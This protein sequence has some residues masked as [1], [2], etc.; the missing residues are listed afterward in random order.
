M[1]GNN[2]SLMSKNGNGNSNGDGNGN[3]NGNGSLLGRLLLLVPGSLLALAR[4]TLTLGV[5]I[6]AHRRRRLGRRP[7]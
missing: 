4:Y 5:C 3:G 6:Y 7:A 2:G 1:H